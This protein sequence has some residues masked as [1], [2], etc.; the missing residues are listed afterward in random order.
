MTHRGPN[1]R[2]TYLEPGVALGVRRL[3]IVDV[4][5]GHQPVSQRGRAVWAVQ[6]GE[7]Y[8]HEDVRRELARAA[9]ASRA[10]ATPRS[11]RTSTRR[12][13]PRFAERVRGKFGIAVWDGRQRRRRHRARPAR[14]Q[15]DLLRAGRRPRRLRLGAEEPAR[16]RSRR[17]RARLRGDRR[18]PDARLRPGPADAAGRRPQADARRAPDRRPARPAPRALLDVPV[19]GRRTRAHREDELAEELL[20]R[21]DEAV[22]AA[23]DERRPARRDAERR[24]RLEPD[25]RADG[26]AH[27]GAGEDV[28]GRLHR[29]SG[30]N[31]LGGRAL[32]R[33][34]SSGPST[35]SSSSRTRQQQIDLAD[36][37]WA[38]DE[39]VADLSSLG[40]LAI[41]ELAARHVTVALSGQGADELLGGLHASTGPR[42]SSPR[43]AGCRRRHARSAQVRS[44]GARCA[45]GGRCGRSWRRTPSTGCS[46]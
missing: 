43:G 13:A 46:R 17:H 24:P 45:P 29:G 32:R 44:R 10:G 26:A 28:L 11:S 35:T 31:E 18:L 40:F 12:S 7:L 14:R 25:R 2:G 38:M 8:N 36:L 15:A 22:R 27:D 42:R 34:R 9:T 30:H 6:N 16:E 4:E 5:G 20:A 41:S 19:A 33:G 39:P 23:A 1:D 3:S 21:L 37:V